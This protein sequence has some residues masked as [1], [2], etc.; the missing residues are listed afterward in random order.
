MNNSFES[1]E[2]STELILTGTSVIK[3]VTDKTDQK[4]VGKY[5]MMGIFTMVLSWQIILRSR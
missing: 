5:L 1:F 4:T 3:N 2:L